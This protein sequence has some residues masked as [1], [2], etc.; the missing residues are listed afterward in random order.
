MR[1]RFIKQTF[2]YLICGH[3]ERQTARM[4]DHLQIATAM[5]SSRANRR[6]NLSIVQAREERPTQWIPSKANQAQK[7]VINTAQLLRLILHLSFKDR[8]PANQ[9]N[10]Q[11]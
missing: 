1:P 3:H 6:S 2:V 5:N 10:S 11:T 4:N 8:E 9:N 7:L